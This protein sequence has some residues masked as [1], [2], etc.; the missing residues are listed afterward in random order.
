MDSTGVT[1]TKGDTSSSRRSLYSEGGN[2]EEGAVVDG[3]EFRFDVTPLGSGRPFSGTEG[4]IA[5]GSRGVPY[6]PRTREDPSATAWSP[7]STRG[8]YQVG[9]RY[10]SPETAAGS[11]G[12]RG[13]RFG[14]LKRSG[15]G[16]MSEQ[17]ME[18]LSD[19]ENRVFLGM[20]Q[21]QEARESGDEMDS[22]VTS[23]ASE[24]ALKRAAEGIPP[25]ENRL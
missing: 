21:R 8:Y 13:E 15:S 16:E 6:N 25:R 3:S 24:R 20:Q 5:S 10:Q 4:S 14:G 9:Q 17:G 1:L 18:D 23:S 11:A 2:E 19:E 7:A 22:T 12:A